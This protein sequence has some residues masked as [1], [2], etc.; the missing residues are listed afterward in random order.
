MKLTMNLASLPDRERIVVE[1]W[2]GNHQFAEVSWEE[3]KP[4]LEIYSS[5]NTESKDYW[6][7]ELDEVLE[8]LNQA[9]K[10]LSDSSPNAE[11]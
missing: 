4:M 7:L 8:A 9:R 1:I 11:K 6:V 5:P 10:Q 3:D 2:Y